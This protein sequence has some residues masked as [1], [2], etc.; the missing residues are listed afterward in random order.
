M[1][2]E[3]KKIIRSLNAVASR[4]LAETVLSYRL[5]KEI[6]RESLKLLQQIEPDLRKW[7]ERAG[8]Q[9]ERFA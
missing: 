7:T 9:R 5:A 3:I 6:K 4:K 2:P 8:L 1:V